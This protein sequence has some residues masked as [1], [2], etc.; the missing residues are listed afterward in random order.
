MDNVFPVFF[1]YYNDHSMGSAM[2]T[3]SGKKTLGDVTVSFFMKQY[4]DSPK[5][6]A[7][8]ASLG[9]GQ[10]APIKVYALFTDSIL[11]IT[12]G[13]LASADIQMT[14]SEGGQTVTA[15][16][17]E[18]IRVLD[19]N[20]MSWFDDRIAAAYI[21][22][23]DPA[24]LGFAKNVLSVV[25]DSVRPAVNKNLQIALALHDAL[26]LYGMTYVLGPQSPSAENHGVVDN[27]Q[28]PRQ[29]LEYKGGKC[30]DLTVLY[31]AL[32]ESVGIETAYITVPG[33]IYAAFD[34]GLSAEEMTKLYSRPDDFIVQ[35]GKVWIPVEITD[36]KGGFF[37][38][39]ATGAKEWRENSQKDV[40][41]FY[42]VHEAWTLF[43]PVGLPGESIAAIP[44]ASAAII[45]AYDGELGKFI[46]RELSPQ[47][48][49]IS[50][51]IAASTNANRPLNSLGV[52]Y[53]KY[54]LY[55]KAASAFNKV[56]AKTDY[57]PTLINMGN[58]SYLQKDL[59]SASRYFQKGSDID[60]ENALVV[61]NLARIS[62]DNGNFEMVKTL[63][64]KLGKLNPALAKQFA[65]LGT[66]EESG[67]RAADV[68][69]Q[70]ET[71]VWSGE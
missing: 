69:T 15:K 30:G 61:L 46:D 57:L 31:S 44:P 41:A 23:K 27:M 47:V 63:Y 34:T 43:E 54:G 40:A 8:V 3:N 65:Y 7:K 20:A 24:I 50:A 17:S 56:L 12:E 62:L 71:M 58:L 33:H 68:A 16:G 19:R 51:E 28:F 4:M 67:T 42:P 11:G 13:T 5:V 21:T 49:R 1:K 29:T 10:S 38:A 35:K 6:I 2:L 52:L 37:E 22:A 32:L 25:K 60:P 59:K 45:T 26:D 39:W 66:P 53:A 70:K 14:Y 36:R 9:P 18:A 48:A 64:A 55:D